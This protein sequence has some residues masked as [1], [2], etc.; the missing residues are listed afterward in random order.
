MQFADLMNTPAEDLISPSTNF[1]PARCYASLVRD[2]DWIPGM[3]WSPSAVFRA[4]G[5]EAPEG[6]NIARGLQIMVRIQM[7]SRLST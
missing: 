1:V 2:I 3:I 4:L 6:I 5:R 7:I